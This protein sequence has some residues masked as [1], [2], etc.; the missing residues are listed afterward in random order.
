MQL[1]KHYLARFI[2]KL[3][4]W[5]VEGALPQG[6]DK[7]VLL[8]VPHT[9]AHDFHM[10]LLS[11]WYYKLNVKWVGKEKL[12]KPWL[13]GVLCRAM[14]G[15][16]VDRH[17]SSN[18]VE[19]LAQVLNACK[20]RLC[21]VIAPNGSRKNTKGW[22]TGFYHIAQTA[23]L[24]IALGFLDYQQKILGVK[25][26]FMPTGNLEADLQLIGTHYTGVMGR[27]THLYCPVQLLPKESKHD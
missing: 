1:I 7:V 26:T 15:I 16:C 21:L 18:S 20:E 25:H 13:L 22:R 2:I 9:S 10:M 3:M 11:A 12:F 19:R 23:K 14:G 27:H 24:P 17:R 6:T 5:R 4:G 8:G